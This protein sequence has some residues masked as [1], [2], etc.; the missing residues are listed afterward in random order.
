MTTSEEHTIGA[1]DG[2]VVRTEILI[3]GGGPAGSAAA[4]TLGCAGRSVV[5]VDKAVFPRDKCCGDG[6]TTGALR[7]LEA[8]GLDP[9]DVA[10]WTVIDTVQMRSPSGREVEMRLPDRASIGQFSAVARRMD[11]DAALLRCA[12]KA[13][14]TLMEGTALRS[15]RTT[16]DAVV[17][18]LDD[19]TTVV[20][21]VAIAADGM[22][23][24]TRRMLGLNEEGYLGEWHA[25]R[26]YFSGVTGPATQR[27]YVWFEPDVLPGYVW[28]F[29]VDGEPGTVNFGFGVPRDGRRIP[30]MKATWADLLERPHIRA[31]LGPT[32]APIDRPTAWPIPARIDRAVMAYGRVLFVGD[33]VGATDIMTGEGI[34]QALLT[35]RLAAEAI[36][37]FPQGASARAIGERYRLGVRQHLFA[38]HRMSV[39]L[40]RILKYRLGA[41]GAIRAV[42]TNDWTRRNFVRWMFE[43]EPRAV[44]L[45]PRRWHRRF[46][47]RQGA[48][49]GHSTTVRRYAHASD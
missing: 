30:D 14:A 48:Y 42:A 8:L 17:A 35:G 39:L 44:L 3:V 43:D 1:V 25:F 24:P 9:A 2:P 26:Q 7:E 29:P 5:V 38:D 33:A 10:S 21:D 12:A 49:L 20:A 45:T 47:T 18:T 40:G 27:Q 31:A 46:L 11:L 23:S 15:I 34:G 28:S 4:I 32:T 22:W 19:G 13:G 37:S 41:R 16:A 36:A 6:L